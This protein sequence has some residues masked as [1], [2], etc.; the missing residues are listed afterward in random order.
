MAIEEESYDE[1]S[2]VQSPCDDAFFAHSQL[3]KHRSVIAVWICSGKYS[4]WHPLDLF[5]FNGLRN[6]FSQSI[7]L[8]VVLCCRT[9]LFII[10]VNVIV[11]I[12]DG[13]AVVVYNWLCPSP[14]KPR[15]TRNRSA[16]A[17]APVPWI[18]APAGLPSPVCWPTSVAR[19]YPEIPVE[20]PIINIGPPV[21]NV[22]N[23]LIAN[24]DVHV[25]HINVVATLDTVPNVVTASIADVWAI[26]I[27]T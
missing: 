8:L 1:D 27:V 12:N 9:G 22:V 26:D 4:Q 10:H 3:Q 2:V 5:W 16:W 11:T 24:V 20:R 18:T 14:S 7:S 6:A 21:S 17:P 19:V 25:A 15:A 23:V 13:R